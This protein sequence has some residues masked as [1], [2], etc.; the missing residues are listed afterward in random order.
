MATGA[1]DLAVMMGH[2]AQYF[3][4]DGDWSNVLLQ[5]HRI[6]EAG[7]CLSFEIRN[8]AIAWED[9]WTEARSKATLPHPGGGEFT[10]WVEV[11]SIR[12]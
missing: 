1:A 7:G 3:V 12:P 8:P 2:V 4:D 10:S 9:R 6:V 5:L 11:V